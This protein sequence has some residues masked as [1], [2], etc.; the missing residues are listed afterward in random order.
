MNPDL[1]RD[2]HEDWESSTERE[3]ETAEEEY[4]CSVFIVMVYGFAEYCPEPQE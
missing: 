2:P 4:S 3:L 1:D